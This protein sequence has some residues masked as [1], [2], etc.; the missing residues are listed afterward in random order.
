MQGGAP[1]DISVVI[2]AYRAEGMIGHTLEALRAQ[3]LDARRFEVVVVDDG[4]PDDTA[5]AARRAGARVIAQ[6]NAGP[7]VARN[8][9]VRES[10]GS[11]IVFTD[12]DCEPEPD[13]LE[14]LVRPFTDPEVGGT[15]GAYRTRQTAW[16][17]RLVQLEYE[18]R[19]DR[20]AR[21]QERAGGIDFIDTYAAAFRRELFEAVGGFDEGFPGASV[22]DQEL[23]FRMAERGV[24]MRFVPEARVWHRHA[25]SWWG[26]ARKKAKIGYWKVGVLR[27]HPDRAV[28]DSHTPQGLKLEVGLAGLLLGAGLLAPL[29]ALAG[30]PGSLL[31]VP[32]VC[33][34]GLLALWLPFLARVAGREPTLVPLTPLFLLTRAVALGMG[35]AAGLVRGVRLGPGRSG[36]GLDAGAA[37]AP[38]VGAPGS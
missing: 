29:G 32:A 20:M 24:R 16:V 14:C 25:D 35:L 31:A 11:T 30:A 34:L 9:G 26:Y 12:A 27:R 22:E 33:L 37:R 23:S 1:P 13:F 19:Y 10:R 36:P 18:S 21:V 4:S 2:A 6:P 28:H 7:A 17:A 15:K 5:G 3:T 8:R 38:A